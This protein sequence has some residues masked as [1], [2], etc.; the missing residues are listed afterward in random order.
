MCVYKPP[1]IEGR[2]GGH[3]FFDDLENLVMASLTLTEN[4]IISGDMNVNVLEF[5]SPDSTSYLNS[6]QLIEK[7][8][9]DLLHHL[10]NNPQLFK[11]TDVLS[12]IIVIMM[13]PLTF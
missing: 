8:T 9:R 11:C 4:L 6:L 2:Y 3:L 5:D 1:E 12:V 13:C 7:P 10:T